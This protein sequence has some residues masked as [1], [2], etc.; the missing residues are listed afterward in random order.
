MQSI[1]AFLP[2]KCKIRGQAAAYL[3]GSSYI[4][5]AA[6]RR[7]AQPQRPYSCII[8]THMKPLRSSLLLLRV[9]AWAAAFA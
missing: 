2:R 5:I 3:R 7:T 4:C 8:Y 9:T 6:A 1:S